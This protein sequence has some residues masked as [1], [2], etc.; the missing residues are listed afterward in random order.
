MSEQEQ[1]NIIF[2]K[3]DDEDE[4]Y[5]H[6]EGST[7]Q[8]PIDLE[9]Q[10][11]LQVSRKTYFETYDAFHIYEKFVVIRINGTNTLVIVEY[12]L[13]SEPLHVHIIED[14]HP[15]YDIDGNNFNEVFGHIIFVIFHDH[16]LRIHLENQTFIHLDNKI[17]CS[18]FKECKTDF[19]FRISRNEKSSFRIIED[20]KN[21][22]LRA[23]LILD[24]ITWKKVELFEINLFSDDEF[25]FAKYKNIFI[26][27]PPNI[28]GIE[29]HLEDGYVI[30]TMTLNSKC[31]SLEFSIYI[32]FRENDGPDSIFLLNDC[33]RCILTTSEQLRRFQQ[34]GF[35]S[36]AMI[37]VCPFEDHGDLPE[38]QAFIKALLELNKHHRSQWDSDGGSDSD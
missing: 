19:S 7:K 27:L 25:I 17:S 31:N 35:E 33:E 18:S 34:I 13:R 5:V 3:Y 22:H 38:I 10:H 36:V 23:C 15:V 2:L 20:D 21:E 14:L 6:H 12:P 4:Q 8:S 28:T 1:L 37:S 16:I 11:E 30:L 24:E 32:D 9:N 26:R 29:I